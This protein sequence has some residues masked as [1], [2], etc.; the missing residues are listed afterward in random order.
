MKKAIWILMFCLLAGTALAEPAP[1]PTP[2]EASAGNFLDSL[3]QTWDAF[4]GMT[5][6]AGS[7]VSDWAVDM[8]KQTDAFL[9][10]NMPELKGW[11][12]EAGSYFEKE[13]APEVSA[14]YDTLLEGAAE[15]GAYTHQELVNAY[16][17]LTESLEA[18]DAN[19]KVKESVDA[20]AKLAG[21]T[22][23]EK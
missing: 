19:P 4:L 15:A 2:L 11:L 8:E 12:D 1:T 7:A 3:G 21:L 23:E 10:E 18:S 5:Q 9:A 14:A 13:V 20:L 6:E 17:T 16:Q 22:V